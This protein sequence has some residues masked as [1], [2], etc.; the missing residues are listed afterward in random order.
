MS[1]AFEYVDKGHEVR[2]QFDGIGFLNKAD[3]LT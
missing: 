1:S 2:Q 3:H